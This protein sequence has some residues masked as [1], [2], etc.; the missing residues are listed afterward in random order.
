MKARITVSTTKDGQFEIWLNEAG[1]DLLVKQLLSLN[2]NNE[3]LHL[4]CWPGVDIELAEQSYRP[5]DTVVGAGEILFRTDAWDREHYPHVIDGTAHVA[6]RSR[7]TTS[8]INRRED[9]LLSI[10][11][12]LVG[13]VTPN[14]RWIACN[15]SNS[16]I[17]V[18][19]GY[20]GMPSPDDLEGMSIVETEIVADFPSLSVQVQCSRS[21]AA[22]K[23]AIEADEVIAYAR[24]E[25]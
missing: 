23:D 19:V 18:R 5:G 10:Q 6:T 1:R 14:V 7:P 9:I 21:D 2:E 16:R 4:G 25:A 17:N 11:R 12:A 22:V 8:A 24:R 15:W 3:H 20:E 13:S